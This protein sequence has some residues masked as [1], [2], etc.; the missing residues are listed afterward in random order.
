MQTDERPVAVHCSDPDPGSDPGPGSDRDPDRDLAAWL[1]LLEKRSSEAHIDLGLARVRQV[2]KGMQTAL[3]APVITVAGTNGKGSTVAMIEAM[4]TAAGHRPLVYTSPHLVSFSERIR[5]GGRPAAEHA[6]AAAFDQVERAR[7]SVTLTYF[8]H[9]TLAALAMASAHDVNAVVLEVG[10]GGRL[11]AVNI[12]D[13][14]VAVITSIGIDHV[15]FLGDDRRSIALEK[16]GIAR[17]ERPVIVGE[18]QPPDGLL[19]HL[20]GVGARITLLN[21][22][23]EQDSSGFVLKDVSGAA[24][25]AFAPPALPGAWQCRNAAL[26]VLALRA[27]RDRLPVSAETMARGLAQVQL[28]GRFQQLSKNPDVIVDVAHNPAAARALAGALGPY[29]GRSTAV[30][31][32]LHDKDVAGIGRALVQCFSDW[33]VAPLATGRGQSAA[34]IINE[35]QAAGVSARMMAVESVGAALEQALADSGPEDRIVVF[36]SFLTAAEALNQWPSR[37]IR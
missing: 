36:G 32:A 19:A 17:S 26:A 11:D 33:L 5:I 10:L 6:I 27:L 21:D 13:P 3:S 20:E 22:V 12:I 1:A 14:D 35:L 18:T 7:G 30:F 4:L 9:I 28:A 23:Y 34:A 16:A 8:E 15:E 25:L 37:R 2:W 24:R 31:S 29:S